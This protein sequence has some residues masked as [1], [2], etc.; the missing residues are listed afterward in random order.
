MGDMASVA[1]ENGLRT[2][3]ERSPHVE[4][5]A[6]RAAP[7]SDRLA[8][9]TAAT[10]DCRLAPPG[11]RGCQLARN[12]AGAGVTAGGD[13]G[14][15]ARGVGTARADAQLDTA[16]CDCGAAAARNLA[17]AS[18][19]ACQP[20]APLHLAAAGDRRR[21]R[22]RMARRL[23][24]GADRRRPR[25]AMAGAAGGNRA[26]A[27]CVHRAPGRNLGGHHLRAQPARVADA[28]RSGAR[29]HGAHGWYIPAVD[30]AGGQGGDHRGAAAVGRAGGV[31]AD[32]PP[33]GARRRAQPVGAAADRQP[34]QD[35][36]D[37]DRTARRPQH[38]GHRSDR[39]Y[40]VQRR[41]GRR[42]R[43][44]AAKDRRQFCQRPHPV[45]RALDQAGRCDRGRPHL[46]QR[47]RDGC[48]LRRGARP[49]RQGIP[50]PERK[51]DHQP[52]DQLVIFE[53]VGADRREIRRRLRQRSAGGAGDGDRRRTTDAARAGGAGPGLPHHRLRRQ[54]RRSRAAVLD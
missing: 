37:F 35:C 10:A 51:P 24:A 8:R 9:F 12:A 1:R 42:P 4:M 30:A 21:H 19:S 40:R 48:A 29:Q 14:G 26:V 6:W 27:R 28:D 36:A 32:H 39:L 41:G 20:A 34:D 52:G 54:R 53:P 3:F 50:D 45:D 2:Q 7:D 13:C 15:A 44:R 23:A 16:T 25:G 49:R 47:R 22:F 11:C 43:L 31:A 18:S 33:S 46:R 17:P 38:G 5:I